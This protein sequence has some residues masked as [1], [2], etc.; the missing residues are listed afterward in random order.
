MQAEQLLT[1]GK[2]KYDGGDRMGALRLWEETLQQ[3]WRG[4]AG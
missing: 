1:Q 3:V 4:R 2:A